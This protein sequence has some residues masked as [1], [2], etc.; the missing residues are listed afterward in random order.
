MNRQ[1]LIV[2]LGAVAMLLVVACGSDAGEAAQVVPATPTAI[3]TT[4]PLSLPTPAPTSTLVPVS[5]VA[6]TAQPTPTTQPTSTAQATPTTQPTPTVEPAPTAT[7]AADAEPLPDSATASATVE[8]IARQT[9]VPTPTAEELE[10][11]VDASGPDAGADADSTP[12]AQDPTAVAVVSGEAPLECYD[13]QVQI[14][15]AFVEGVDVLSFEG[16]RVYC[17]GAGSSAV[18][19]ARSYRHASGL[20]VNRNADYMF[21]DAGTGYIPY[22][23]SVHFCLNGQPASAPVV[24]DTVPALLVVIEGEVQ[25]QVAQGAIG[26]SEFTAA[27]SQ[28]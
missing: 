26:P 4:A 16:G 20:I 3:A 5:E 28:C 1:A 15:R 7:V 17:S 14:Y 6:P 12:V 23:G 18:S 22:S 25:R 10:T 11:A 13:T 2:T 9:P 24:A 19:A 8:A 27:G 21:N